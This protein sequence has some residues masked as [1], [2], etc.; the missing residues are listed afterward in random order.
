MYLGTQVSA[1]ACL[2]CLSNFWNAML[3]MASPPQPHRVQQAVSRINS[4]ARNLSN[5]YCHLVKRLSHFMKQSTAA[6]MPLGSADSSLRFKCAPCLGSVYMEYTGRQPYQKCTR[7]Q[8]C[9][10]QTPGRFMKSASRLDRSL[11]P[12]SFCLLGLRLSRGI[13]YFIIFR[14]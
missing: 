12:T 3:S 5:G 13:N 14:H 6:A 8:Q 7:L 4:S 1:P 9:A 11:I 2:S 10:S